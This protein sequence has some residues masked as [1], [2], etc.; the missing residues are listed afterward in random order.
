MPTIQLPNPADSWK[1]RRREIPLDP[2][3]AAIWA[4]AHEA[5]EIVR[6]R[7]PG[8]SDEAIYLYLADSKNVK[9]WMAPCGMYPPVLVFLRADLEAFSI[10]PPHREVPAPEP[11]APQEAAADVMIPGVTLPK[12]LP[13]RHHKRGRREGGGPTIKSRIEAK[14]QKL[15]NDGKLR[16]GDDFN[17]LADTLA[18]EDQEL[19]KSPRGSIVRV[20]RAI[21]KRHFE[22]KLRVVKPQTIA[23]ANPKRH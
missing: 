23:R 19:A 21:V 8:Q 18:A 12:P 11:P 7:C 5:I 15:L 9:K 17:P 1:P 2:R 6:P 20:I 16:L 13:E 14:V 3:L 22:V 10:G 4:E